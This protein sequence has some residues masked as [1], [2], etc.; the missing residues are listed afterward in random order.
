[1]GRGELRTGAAQAWTAGIG[2][3][4]SGVLAA[5]PLRMAAVVAAVPLGILVA[6]A[7]HL[8]LLGLPLAV[9]LEQRLSL[10]LAGVRV[11]PV[12]LLIGAVL[13]AWVAR[14]V[15]ARRLSWSP[16]T[17]GWAL[18][19]WLWIMGLSL[20]SALSLGAGL[21]EGSKWLEVLALV[22]VVPVLLPRSQ[23]RYLIWTL[24]GAGALSSLLGLC[25]FATGT[26]PE[27]F[28]ILGRFM[29][30]Y[31]T[32]Q[33]P[34]PFAA[35]L[36][37]SLPFAAGWALAGPAR[38]QERLALLALASAMVLG[39]LASWS[40]G[41]WLAMAGSVAL[42]AALLRPRLATAGAVL[43][44]ITSPLWVEPAGST[45]L[46]Q[47]A[48]GMTG[49]VTG[50]NVARVEPTDDN[51]AVVERLAHWQAAWY[52][53]EDDP[54]LGVGAG[55]YEVVYGRYAVPRWSDPLGHAHNYYLN[56]LAETGMLG[57]AA[58]L[59]FGVAAWASVLRA[60]RN[61]AD[62]RARALVLA[63]A[64]ALAYLTVHS[65]VDNLY[66]HGMQVLI[67]LTLAVPALVRPAT[68]GAPEPKRERCTLGL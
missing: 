54:W 37:L 41:A 20:L 31:G 18:L 8:L 34:N 15:A 19:V 53:F 51:W 30:A 5:A 26:G 43:L 7:P 6:T 55:N 61:D 59:A 35:H 24:A 4:L 10:G 39:I 22:V 63:A 29:R 52:M 28:L 56:V 44:L 14:G 32:F 50:L 21:V 36:G 2:L 27:G 60:W 57:L 11:G 25:Q 47:R 68:D 33:Q 45:A 67:G 48:L 13:A 9:P 23:V 12:E 66:V 46:A 16:G 42:M 49:D 40:R 62:S 38:R 17:I 65:V 3:V 64:G 1:M 58:Y